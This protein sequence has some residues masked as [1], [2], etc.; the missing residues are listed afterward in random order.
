MV[1]QTYDYYYDLTGA[2]WGAKKG[3]EP[4]H[5][6]WNCADNSVK[7]TN[8]TKSGVTKVTAEA[9]IYN[10]N[11]QEVKSMRNT[12]TVDVGINTAKECFVL[13]FDK[14][15]NL[16]F[17]KNTFSS[18]NTEDVGKPSNVTDGNPG[19]RWSSANV[20]NEWMAIDLGSVTEFNAVELDWEAAYAKAYKI[21]V[22]NDSVSWKEIYSSDKGEGGMDNI[23]LEPVK[24]RYVKVTGLKRAIEWGFSLFEFK[25]FNEK[26]ADKNK[27]VLSN[28]HFVQLTLKDSDG[29]LISDNF[30]WRGNKYLDYTGLNALPEVKLTVSTKSVRKD[31][32]YFIDAKIENP[33]SS[34]A[35]AFAVRLQLLNSETGKRILPVFMTDNYFSLVKGESR[36][37]RFEFDASMVP[38]GNVKLLVNPYV[39]KTPQIINIHLSKK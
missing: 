37:V 25:V 34:Q 2:Y 28:V 21:Q 15:V 36:M 14:E 4:L 8:T 6:L 26:K 31:G 13:N 16:A 35:V 23:S 19:S 39:N 18:S 7:V 38:S 27:D 33:G 32:K 30:Y 12:K 3:S 20:D 5:I 10:L 1:W 11:G 9:R 24:A 29:K 22:S 17:G